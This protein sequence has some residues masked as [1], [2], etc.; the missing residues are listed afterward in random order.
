MYIDKRNSNEG[1]GLAWS[2]MGIRKLRVKSRGAEKIKH[3]LRKEEKNMVH[4]L[5]KCK[6]TEVAR[7][8]F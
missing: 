5:L 8:I 6:D 4:T 1:I 2:R 7:K 3:C